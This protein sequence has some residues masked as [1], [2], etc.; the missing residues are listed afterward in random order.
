MWYHL[1]QPRHLWQ[2]IRSTQQVATPTFGAAICLVAHVLSRREE[3]EGLGR[4]LH[5]FRKFQLWRIHD[6]PMAKGIHVSREPVAPV[7]TTGFTYESLN[8]T[9]TIQ[10]LE[11]G[12]RTSHR[13]VHSPSLDRGRTLHSAISLLELLA[14]WS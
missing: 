9:N 11:A 3:G 8:C 1:L 14:Y 5:H 6:N 13:L 4:R 10:S 12:T 7:F 2:I